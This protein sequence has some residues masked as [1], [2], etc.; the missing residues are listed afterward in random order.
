[1]EDLTRLIAV[2]RQEC[3]GPA[4]PS[5]K[6]LADELLKRHGN[7]VRAIL[8]YGS[9]FRNGGGN[10]EGIID[11]YLLVDNY[12]HAYHNPFHAFL[13][14]LLPP[15]VYYLEMPYKEGLIRA[16]YTVFSV[17]DFH[18]GTSICW[19]HSYLWSRIAQPLGIVYAAGTR[20][21]EQIYAAMANS[22]FT[23]ITRVLP[24][25]PPEFTCRELW[26]KGLELTYSSELRAEKQNKL[27][28]LFEFAPR[29]YE[30]VTPIALEMVSFSIAEN[31]VKKAPESYMA[32]I[33][34]R[35]RLTNR[36][37]WTIR[38]IQGKILSFFRLLKGLFTFD[39]GPDYIL[40]KIERHSGVTVQ[41]DPRLKR[42]PIVGSGILFWR[43]YRR[44]AFR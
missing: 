39:G 25:L 22:V 37:A 28:T 12:C 20:E 8:F 42:I 33:P 1:M 43:L 3:S 24:S 13:N 29:Y 18:Q 23:F 30:K 35:V 31:S 44:G 38:R 5:I 32:S 16:K 41:I 26:C 40:W 17:K 34:A 19:F 6:A 21:S 7:A 10:D 11:L 2:I 4:H 36:M 14:K 9:C 27:F 15:N